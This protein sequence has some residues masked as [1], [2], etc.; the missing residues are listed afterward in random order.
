MSFSFIL[1]LS[2]FHSLGHKID[3]LLLDIIINFQDGG[4]GRTK[5][6]G[7]CGAGS[8]PVP[9]PVIGGVYSTTL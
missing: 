2:G 1:D 8:A 5:A 4:G 7:S 3:V 9:V 6:E